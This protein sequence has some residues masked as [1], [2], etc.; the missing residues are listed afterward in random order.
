MITLTD[1]SFQN[2]F[3]RNIGLRELYVGWNGFHLDG[4]KGLMK[5]LQQNI[6][7]RILDLSGNRVGRESLD[8]LLQGLRTNETLSTLKVRLEVFKVTQIKVKLHL[9]GLFF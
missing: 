2:S 8:Y 5:A 4:C 7:L 6:T 9:D 1:K 3:Q